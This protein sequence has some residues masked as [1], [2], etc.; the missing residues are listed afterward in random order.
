MRIKSSYIWKE[1]NAWHIHLSFIVFNSDNDD[2]RSLL[3]S[4]TKSLR[5]LRISFPLVGS[6]KN[7]NSNNDD[8]CLLNDHM[9]GTVLG[10]I[11]ALTHFCS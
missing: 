11:H 5:V 8:Y 4:G 2:H 6:V 3:N 9:T 10:T 7:N 1:S